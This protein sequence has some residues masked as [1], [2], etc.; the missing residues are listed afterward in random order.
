MMK[1]L[2]LS[3]VA[4]L[5]IISS[6]PASAQSAKPADVLIVVDTVRLNIE[7]LY[8]ASLKTPPSTS[9]L[10]L[11]P[12]RPRHVYRK[13]TEVFLKTQT[14]RRLNGLDTQTL[15]PVPTSEVTPGDVR[16][17][18][19]GISQGINELL[20]IYWTQATGETPNRRDNATPTD[21]YQ[22][23]HQLSQLLDGLGLPSVVP[24][25]V[26]SVARLV[27]ID[28]G[29][30]YEALRGDAFS[31]SAIDPANGKSPGDVYAEA[32]AFYEALKAYIESD[33]NLAI[34]GGV[35][36]ADPATGRITP[37]L[38]MEV[39]SNILADLS[40]LKV[41]SNADMS[42]TGQELSA[43]MTPSNVF[44]EFTKAQAILRALQ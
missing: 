4:G 28:M 16:G 42:S 33:E 25:D 37:A 1:S 5:L 23:L 13:A 10:I 6:F 14:L 18:V 3:I 9:S 36:I 21:V 41:V 34:P 40:S 7:K 35:N 2:F 20:P 24:N 30:I 11:P 12:R 15:P 19:I 29:R 44:D 39:T 8:A 22:N 32:Y 31:G 27:A 26:H 38:V 43:G 17:L